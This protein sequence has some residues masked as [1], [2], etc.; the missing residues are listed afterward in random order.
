MMFEF[1]NVRADGELRTKWDYL[2]RIVGDFALSV[3]GRVL[4]KEVDFCLV[5]FAVTLA[6]WLSI[7]T[8]ARPDFVYT[9]LESETEGLVRFDR[10]SSD[11]WRVCAAYQDQPLADLV[12]TEELEIAALTYISSLRRRLAPRL[13]I[14]DC[15]EDPSVRGALYQR[16][17]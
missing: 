13:D 12:T 5:E 10:L 16:L 15:V 7:A 2:L 17:G 1:G 4:Y 11:G 3:R 14:L 8:D 6:N 9:S